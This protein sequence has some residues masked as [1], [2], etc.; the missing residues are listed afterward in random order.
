MEL[1]FKTIGQTLT[2]ASSPAEG[3]IQ[4]DEFVDQ[5]EKNVSQILEDLV[6]LKTITKRKPSKPHCWLT[7]DAIKAKRTRRK[8]E[9]RWLHSKKESDRQAY[10]NSCR[11]A[12]KLI[13][14]SL[15]VKHARDAPKLCLG[16][17]FKLIRCCPGHDG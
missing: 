2:L 4:V 6:P 11:V 15:R 5:I 8:L 9:R 3:N 7:D 14:E 17:D 16:Y 1:Q 13:T 12:N 10:R